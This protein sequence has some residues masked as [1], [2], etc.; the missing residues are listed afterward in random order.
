MGRIGFSEIC[1]GRIFSKDITFLSCGLKFL[2]LPL[3]C[4]TEV[5]RRMVF[6]RKSENLLCDSSVRQPLEMSC[7]QSPGNARL[8]FCPQ[9]RWNFDKSFFV[10]VCYLAAVL[11]RRRAGKLF[12]IF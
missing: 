12:K 11:I 1:S 6:F 4:L 3:G 7:L 2:P 9:T 8:D 10:V 5:K